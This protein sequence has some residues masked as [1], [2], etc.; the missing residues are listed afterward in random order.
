M[1]RTQQLRSL[2]NQIV[3]GEGAHRVELD[4]AETFSTIIFT[5]QTEEIRAAFYE[6]VSQDFFLV[7]RNLSKFSKFRTPGPSFW[8][9]NQD[10][11][12]LTI[13]ACCGSDPQNISNVGETRA[14][15]ASRVPC[16]SCRT[17]GSTRNTLVRWN[18]CSVSWTTWTWQNQGWRL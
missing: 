9:A 8:S 1:T 2:I 17:T 4:P 10:H 5:H 12:K 16:L 7:Q 14:T 11:E 15:Q 18:M 13:F 6:I 3:N